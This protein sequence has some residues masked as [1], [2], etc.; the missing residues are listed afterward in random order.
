MGGRLYVVTAIFMIL[1]YWTVYGK[2][3]KLTSTFLLAVLIVTPVA[4]IGVSR[5]GVPLNL[6]DAITNFALEPVFT[7]FS[8]IHFLANDTIELIRFPRLLI[9]DFINIVP[10]AIMPNKGYYILSPSDLGYIEYAPVGARQLFF[11]LMLNFGLIGSLVFAF[12][13]G[14]LMA[15]LK[16]SRDSVYT[17]VIYVMVSAN[18]MF[19]F[20][21]DPFSVSIVKNIFQFSILIP[22]VLIF[23]ANRNNFINKKGEFS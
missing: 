13:L 11:S 21:R 19:T 2:G 16:T 23:I 3:L 9:S 4:A 15:W 5:L 18:F 7:S 22:L 12:I 10:S 8:T 20:F 17:R 14:W 6:Q 1:I